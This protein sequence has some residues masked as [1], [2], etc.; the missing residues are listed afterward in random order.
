MALTDTLSIHATAAALGACVFSA[1]YAT[2]CPSVPGGDSGELIQVAI[3]GGVA[4]PPGYPTWTMM[5]YAFARLV[6]YGEPAWRVNLASAVCGSLASAFL[7]A[8]VGLW[9]ECAW[10]G[11]AAGGAFAFAPLVWEYAVQGEVF[12]LNNLNNALLLYLLVRYERRPSLGGACAGA[13]AIG[14][15]L[16]NQHTMVFFCAPYAV[17][18]LVVGGADLFTPRALACL[19]SSGLAGLMPYAYLPYASG[20]SAA[21]GSWGDQSTPWG[22]ATHVLRREYGTF[23]LANTPAVT[24]SE[25]AL[26]LGRYLSSVPEELPLFGA[27]LLLLGVVSCIAIELSALSAA[28]AAGRAAAAGGGCA[29]KGA[30]GGDRRGGD[31]GKSDSAPTLEPPKAAA[32]A[33]P[34]RVTWAEP[35]RSQAP[36]PTDAIAGGGAVAGS[37]SGGAA[38]G[39]GGKSGGKSG[40]ISGGISGGGGGGGSSSSSENHA[41][42]QRHGLGLLLPTAYA[43]YVLIFNYLSNLPAS[44]AFYLAVQQRFWPQ[45][46]LL[47]AV[48]Y[49]IGLRHVLAALSAPTMLPPLPPLPSLPA[50]L[51]HGHRLYGLVLPAAVGLLVAGHYRSHYAAA[52]MSE[53]TVFRDF[54]IAILE[55]LPSKPNVVL[56][57]LGDEVLNA[58]RYAHRQLGHRPNMTILDLNYMQYDWFIRRVNGSSAFEGFTFPGSNYGSAPGAYVMSQL[59]DANYKGFRFFVCGGM[60][61]N[62]PTWEAGYRLWPLGMVMQVLKRSATIRLDKWATKSLKLLPRLEWHAP[63]PAGSW[64]EVIAKNHYAVAYHVRPFYVLNYGYEAMKLIEQLNDHMSRGVAPAGAGEAAERARA[65]ARERFMLAGRLFEQGSGIVL[66]GSRS[67]P[68]Y[69]YRNWGVAYSQIIGLE[70]SEEGRA[71]AKQRAAQAFM[72]YL[73]F[74]SV[75]PDD[76]TAVEQGVLS[77]I[78]PPQGHQQAQAQQQQAQQQ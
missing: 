49:A 32:P 44:S 35:G 67:L 75:E 53:V 38:G 55:A 46:H 24:D 29:K 70:P 39:G 63:P 51:P 74:D 37:S 59:L 58:V 60:H 76:R 5:A 17:W 36:S 48:W 45:A 68:D 56:L 73:R 4:H 7:S 9:V 50:L 13:F 57:T 26:R 15:A 28:W 61:A 54:G 43:L 11:V 64:A 77:L 69:Y 78:P 42:R 12:A 23:R 62:D 18:A 8:A 25:Y 22:F 10:T 20:P 1:Y 47:C 41:Q 14:L 6:P 52:D 2:L 16:C 27:P 31:D 71:G 33:P 3:E 66:N 72:S 19:A 40:G 21:W 34:R 65:D 30:K